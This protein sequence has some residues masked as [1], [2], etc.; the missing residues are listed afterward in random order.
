MTYFLL[1]STEDGI[2]I[3]SYTKEELLSAIT[4]GDDGGTDLGAFP[5]H[6][7]DCMPEIDKGCWYDTPEDAVL[8]IEGEILQPQAIKTVTKYKL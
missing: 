7:L 1:Q 6:F 8:I 4:P 2:S 5:L 3:S